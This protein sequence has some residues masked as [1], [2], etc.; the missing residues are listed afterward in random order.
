MWSGDAGRLLGR[1]CEY[2]SQIT[3]LDC[4]PRVLTARMHV[5]ERHAMHGRVKNRE[6]EEMW[7]VGVPPQD[8]LEDVL[9]TVL[10]TQREVRQAECE[11]K[12]LH[13]QEC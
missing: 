11:R 7:L 3:R 4:K 2:S 10:R 12:S 5:C 9:V 1:V 13:Q 6:T 8:I